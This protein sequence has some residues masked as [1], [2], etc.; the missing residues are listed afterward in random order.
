VGQLITHW[1]AGVEARGLTRAARLATWFNEPFDNKVP[2]QTDPMRGVLGLDTQWDSK[3]SDMADNVSNDPPA[4]LPATTGTTRAWCSDGNTWLAKPSCGS[5]TNRTK[6]DWVETAVERPAWS[7]LV[8]GSMATFIAREGTTTPFSSKT[9]PQTGLP[10]GKAVVVWI[11]LWDC[12]QQF[13]SGNWPDPRRPSPCVQS[14]RDVNRVHIFSVIPVTFYEG[15]VTTKA[16]VWGYWGGG[17]VDPGRCETAPLSCKGLN[18]LANTAF[19]VRDDGPLASSGGGPP[20]PPPP[21]PGDEDGGPNWD[22]WWDFWHGRGDRG[23]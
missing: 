11:Y 1:D 18:P 12:G 15:L 4:P 5:G 19:Y 2:Y 9:A 23:D 13:Q 3:R 16:G 22:D 21:P 14:A 10:Y 7:N 17:F 8:D 20:P 6:G